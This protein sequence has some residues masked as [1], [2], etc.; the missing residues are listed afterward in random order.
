M[1]ISYSSYY[2]ILLGDAF[3]NLV[4]NNFFCL[5]IHVINGNSVMSVNNACDSSIHTI[6]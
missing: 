6:H 1:P 4:Y 2:F 5:L 3:A